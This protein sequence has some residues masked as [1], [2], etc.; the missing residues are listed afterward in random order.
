MQSRSSGI[1]DPKPQQFV[2]TIF[3]PKRKRKPATSHKRTKSATLQNPAPPTPTVTPPTPKTTALTR[4][5]RKEQGL[6]RCGEAAIHEQTR[7]PTCTEKHRAYSEDRRRAKGIKPHPPAKHTELIET[8]Q[9]EPVQQG[10]HGTDQKPKRVRSETHK[11]AQREKQAK[12]RAER[13]SQGLCRNCGKPRPEGQTRCHD[14]VI[15]QSGYWKTY[16][17]KGGRN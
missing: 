15:R 8:L 14:C 4:Q 7:C 5:E 17:A 6:C 9:K 16:V 11:K 3:I 12:L 2:D 10:N 1:H 13:D